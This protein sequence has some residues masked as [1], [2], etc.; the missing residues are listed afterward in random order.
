[1]SKTDKNPCPDGAQS[2]VAWHPTNKMR[3]LAYSTNKSVHFH[4]N[5]FHRL[6]SRIIKSLYLNN[7]QKRIY[8]LLLQRETPI[9]SLIG[10]VVP[11]MR[12]NY[13]QCVLIF[14]MAVHRS[15]CCISMTTG[16]QYPVI[17]VCAYIDIYMTL[18]IPCT[19]LDWGEK[20]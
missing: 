8:I 17:Q 6:C 9:R 20:S 2:L 1:M 12:K 16:P 10:H 7:C 18:V 14:N 19:V 4:K 15:K 5:Y 13:F 11:S 3:I